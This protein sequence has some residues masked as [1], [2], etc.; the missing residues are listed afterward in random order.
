MKTKHF[1]FAI[2][3]AALLAGAVPAHAHDSHR[4][5]WHGGH[6]YWSNHH[7]VIY[8]NYPHYGYYRPV[9]PVIPVP[10]PPVVIV[11]P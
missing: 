1:L 6:G 11:R 7:T 10:I 3:A 4:D 9:A 2:S 5:H 8:Q